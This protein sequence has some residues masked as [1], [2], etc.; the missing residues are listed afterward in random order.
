METLSGKTSESNSGTATKVEQ[1]K[2]TPTKGLQEKPPQT[3]PNA[4]QEKSNNDKS[5][6]VWLMTLALSNWAT[7]FHDVV[8]TQYQKCCISWLLFF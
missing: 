5:M 4:S 3:D 7:L 6:Y 2:V 8:I 1:T